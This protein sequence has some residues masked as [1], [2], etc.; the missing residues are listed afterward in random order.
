MRGRRTVVD[1]SFRT[2]CFFN[3]TL[4]QRW[5]KGP[6]L[7][8]PK[9]SGLVVGA[10]GAALPGVVRS[11][12]ASSEGFH[13]L[14]N[15]HHT[16]PPQVRALLPSLPASHCQSSQ[17]RRTAAIARPRREGCRPCLRCS[18]PKLCSDPARAELSR[19]RRTETPR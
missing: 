1:Y 5:P 19:R 10:W 14:E 15:I 6:S 2:R 16:P 11:S 17:Q 13:D 18:M 3:T 8:H 9:G 4:T 12:S 7:W